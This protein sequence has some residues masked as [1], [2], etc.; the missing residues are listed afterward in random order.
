MTFPV[1]DE[2]PPHETHL[3]DKAW[4]SLAKAQVEP[5]LPALQ[6]AQAPVEAFG[7]QSGYFLAGNHG[8]G[9]HL[10]GS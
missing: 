5:Q 9:L 2:H 4:T 7:N 1:S 8:I 6:A 10:T 3:L